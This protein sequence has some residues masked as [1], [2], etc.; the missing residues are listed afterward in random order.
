MDEHRM[1]LVIRNDLKMSKGKVCA[2]CCHAAI[3]TYIKASVEAIKIWESQSTTKITVKVNSEDE[4]LGL[5]LIVE[6]KN[7]PCHLVIDEGRTQIKAGSCTV[8][9]IGP[10][11]K[12]VLNEII[13]H[14]KLY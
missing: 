13:G 2:Q 3:G 12:T 5:Q 4:L 6:D 9:G 10:A 1:I 7:I 11:P 14:L 8:L